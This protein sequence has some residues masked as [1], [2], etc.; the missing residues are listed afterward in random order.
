MLTTDR[1]LTS[2]RGPVTAGLITAALLLVPGQALAM[3]SGS[4][5]IEANAEG[6]DFSID[7][8]ELLQLQERIDSL[9]ELN[10]ALEADNSNLSQAVED[11]T[12]QRDRLQDSLSRFDELYGPLDAD[13]Q[14][15][16]ELRKDLP[17]TRVEAEA[18]LDRLERLALIANPSRLGQ[19]VDRVA[20][21][22]PAF[23]D[24]RFTQFASTQEASEAYVQSGANAFDSTLEELRDAVLLSVANRIDGLL[25]VIDRA[26]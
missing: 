21:A 7:S 4:A 20:D 22:A 25:T 10:L 15:L 12:R 11:V 19:L 16:F 17:E 6:S 26:R 5:E 13:R 8:S 9:S 23:L 2:L 18:Q 14:L 3:D 1:F 24:W